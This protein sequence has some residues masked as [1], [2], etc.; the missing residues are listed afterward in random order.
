MNSLWMKSATTVFAAAG[1]LSQA[2]FGA[3][4]RLLS[5]KQEASMHLQNTPSFMYVENYNPPPLDVTQLT[6][7][8]GVF[9]QK[10]RTIKPLLQ[11]TSPQKSPDL[12]LA[13]NKQEA[14]ERRIRQTPTLVRAGE[15]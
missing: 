6:G 4:S 3:P 11:K 14:F 5:D 7:K 1:F 9:E 2:S 10:M 12:S 15:Q 8:L 13:A